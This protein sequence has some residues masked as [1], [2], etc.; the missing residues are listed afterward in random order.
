MKQIIA[1]CIIVVAAAEVWEIIAQWGIRELLGKEIDFV[2]EEDLG[3]T[4]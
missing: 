2:Q 4:C 1:G 3:R